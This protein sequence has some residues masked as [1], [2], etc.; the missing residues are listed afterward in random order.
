[1]EQMYELRPMAE[2]PHPVLLNL[3]HST[4]AHFDRYRFTMRQ[5][6]AR[7][8]AHEHGFGLP[9]NFV[10][11]MNAFV[12]NYDHRHPEWHGTAAEIEGERARQ[13]R[14]IAA[15][16]IPQATARPYHYGH[17]PLD[18]YEVPEEA[19]LPPTRSL[20][21]RAEDRRRSS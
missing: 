5:A 21:I 9:V 16:T 11:R 20:A 18:P 17:A 8:I 14:T 12:G 19:P 13:M 4:P 2:W 1:M 10:E 15:T 7:A 3:Y 6:V